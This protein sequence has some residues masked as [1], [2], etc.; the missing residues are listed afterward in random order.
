M[1]HARLDWA[2][3]SQLQV[4]GREHF[5]LEVQRGGDPAGQG[6]GVGSAAC[7]FSSWVL[8]QACTAYTHVYGYAFSI[9][10]QTRLQLHSSAITGIQTV[11]VDWESF[12]NGESPSSFGE[13]DVTDV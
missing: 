12:I 9:K 13:R 3:L 11:T 5:V 10:C 4:F 7:E 6:R 1:Q 8:A 2:P